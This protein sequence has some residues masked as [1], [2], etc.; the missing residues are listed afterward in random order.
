MRNQR[1]VSTIILSWMISTGLFAQQL[2]NAGFE[3]WSGEKYDNNIQPASWHA[4]NVTQV[5]FKFT[6][7]HQ[8]S[9]HTGNYCMQVGDQEV[10]AMGITETAPGYFSLGNSWCYLPSITKIKEATAGTEGGIAW[11]YRPDSVSVWI[12]RTGNNVRKENFNIVYYAWSGTTKGEKYKGKNGNCSPTSHTDE[13]GD[14]RQAL[15]GNDCGTLQKANQIAEGWWKEMKEYG[16]WTNLRIPIYYINNDVP[17][18]MNLLF[19]AGNYPNFCSVDG[20]YAG[21]KLF[22][23]DVSL[24]Y[25]A[26]IQQI[27]IDDK[28]WKGFDSNS[29]DE[30]TYSLG[31]KATVMPKIECRR[32]VG[33]LTNMR[34][35]TVSFPGRVLQGSECVITP[36]VIDGKPTEIKVTSD[37][38]QSTKIYK[39][40]FVRAPSTNAKLADLLVNGESIENFNPNNISY[41]VALPFGT[42][43]APVVSVVKAED[44]QTVT[45]T[46]S[47]STTG[48][49]TVKVTA[50]DKKTTK[51]Y[52]ISFSV[53][54]LADN[55]LTDITV[56]GNS[57][58]DFDSYRSL[59][60]ISLPLNTTTMPKVVGLSAYPA[61]AQ[62]ITYKA[63]AQIDGGKY[64][65][66]VSV[67][68]NP[69]TR[70]YTLTF[71]LEPS[72]YSL[73]KD[74]SMDGGYITGFDPHNFTYYVD[75][76]LGTNK[77][78]AIHYVKGD[79]YQTV[80]IDDAAGLEGTNRI[81]V[82]A[83]DGSQ[84]TYKLIT[85][86]E[87]S[88]RS[89]LKDIKVG[90]V[91]ISGFDPNKTTYTYDLPIGTS[92][93][94]TIEPVPGDEFEEIQVL[95]N[96]VNGTTRI[97]V[98]AGD[99]NTTIYQITFSVKK[100]SDAT[101]KSITLDGTEI[102]NYN[103]ETLEYTVSL[104]KGTT[105]HPTVGYVPNDAFQ[106]INV[107]DGGLNGDYKITVRPQSGASRE[108]IIHFKV[109][110]SSNVT[111]KDIAIGGTTIEN[112]APET[113]DYTIT[114]APGI[115]TI[116]NNITYVPAEASQKIMT[117]REGMKYVIRVTAESGAR[118]EY[119]INFIVQKSQN[120]F[121]KDILLDG[122]SIPNFDKE[123]FTYASILTGNYSPVITAVP[124]DEGQQV[125]ITAPNAV[126][127]AQI[128]VIPEQGAPNTYTI[129]FTK[130]VSHNVQL[131]DIAVDGTT[132]TGFDPTKV[133]YT[134]T[135]EDNVP[136][137][138]YTP[139]TA[140]QQVDK[141]T[142]KNFVYLYVTDGTEY[143]TY[144]IDLQK[145]L[146]S[147]TSITLYVDGNAYMYDPATTNVI[148][149]A[150]GATDPVIT[151][152]AADY[153][154]VIYAGYKDANTYVLSAVSETGTVQDYTLTIVR[155]KYTDAVLE[156]LTLQGGALATS[157]SLD[158]NTFKHTISDYDEG[159]AL[160]QII[161]K[162]KAGQ[163]VLVNEV[164]QTK[165]Q[166]IVTAEDGTTNTY[167]ITYIPTV[168]DNALL[169]DILIDNVALQGFDPNTHTYT[170]SLP[171]DT[172]V[173]PC[174]HPV[175]QLD[176]QT[177][178]TK[179]G[180]IDAPTV[181]EVT[182][183]DGITKTTYTLNFPV[184]RSNNCDLKSLDIEG[185]SNFTFDKDITDYDIVLDRRAV[186]VPKYYY[187]KT[188]SKQQIRCVS[189]PIGQTSE[190]TVI[191][192]DGTTKTYRL[193]FHVDF[194]TDANEL[195]TLT[196]NGYT[197][198]L[199]T[200]VY[201]YN[202]PLMPYGTK[203]CE[204]AYTKNYDEQTVVVTNGGIYR[205]TKIELK[206]NRPNESNTVYTITP[207][208]DPQ[209]P[210]VAE[211][212]TIGG[213]DLPDFDKNRFTYVYDLKNI[214]TSKT[215]RTYPYDYTDEHADDW[216]WQGTI[217]KD[218]F[219]NT[220][221]IYFH[222]S[223]DKIPNNH[224][225]EW[226]KT[227]K[228]NSDKPKDWNAPG[229]YL[230][231]YPDNIFASIW[232]SD[233]VSKADATTVHLRTKNGASIMGALPAKINLADMQAQFA[234]AGGSYVT[235]SGTKAFHNTPDKAIMKYRY[236]DM[237]GNGAL[238]RFVFQTKNGLITI[239]NLDP[240]ESSNDT[241]HSKDLG[242]AGM[243]VSAYD[244]IIDATGNAKSSGSDGANLYVD[245]VDFVYNNTA[246]DLTVNNTV[247]E[248]TGK[249][250]VATLLSAE[251]DGIPALTFN[252]EVVDQAQKITWKT[253]TKDADNETRTAEIINYGEDGGSQTYTLKVIR[254]LSTVTTLK[255]ITLT[256]G[257]LKEAFSEGRT[258][259]TC[260]IPSTQKQLPDVQFIPT[261]KLETLTT[262]YNAQDST[263]T[264]TVTSEKKTTQTY[265]LKFITDL[266]SDADLQSLTA[267]GVSY[268]P[269]QTDYTVTAETLPDITFSKKLDGQVVEQNEKGVI[270][271]TAEDGTEKTYRVS[272]TAPEDV[273]VAQLN[274]IAFN[275]NDY[276]GGLG[277]GSFDKE[278]IKRINPTFERMDTRDS[279]VYT[280]TPTGL[281]W[282]VVGGTT[283]GGAEKNTY[284]Y[285]YLVE[286]S[287]NTLL[288]DITIDG[289]SV[290][291]FAPQVNDYIV[292]TNKAI[293]VDV[294]KAE[295]VQTVTTTLTGNKYVI[296]VTAE[297]GTTTNTYSVT[298]TPQLSDNAYLAQLCVDGTNILVGTQ[299]DYVQEIP[300]GAAKVVEPQMPSITYVVG[301]IGQ[302]VQVDRG[303]LG[304]PTTLTVTSPDGNNVITYNV[305]ISAEPSHNALLNNIAINGTPVDERFESTRHYYTYIATTPKLNIT[306]SSDDN[307][308][309]VSEQVS[310]DSKG[311][312]VHS[313]IVTAQDGVT[314]NKY[315]VS[316]VRMEV[317]H[318]TMLSNILLDN[319]N[320]TVYVPELNT[321]LHFDANNNLYSVNLQSTITALPDVAALLNEDGQE[322]S[323]ET[324][325]DDVLLHVTAP[326]GT[327]KN[328]YTVSFKR[329]KSNNANLDDIL[330]DGVSIPNF[331]PEQYYYFVDLPIGTTTIPE[332]FAQKHEEPQTVVQTDE[333]NKTVLTVT[334]EDGVTT[335][336]YDILYNFLQSDIDTLQ[337][338]Y[339]DG[340]PVLEHFKGFEFFY[341]ITLPVGTTTIP[342]LSW[343]EGDEWQTV[344]E[345]PL[346]ATTSQL[347]VTSQSGKR[348]IYTVEFE[349]LLSDVDTLAGLYVNGEAVENF[350]S[351]TNEYYITLP[352]D[353]TEVPDLMWLEG[354]EYQTITQT[355]LVDVMMGKS[356]GQKVEL[357]VQAQKGNSRTYTLHFPV[358]LSD[359][360]L[361][362]MIFVSGSPV[363]NYDSETD[364]YTITLPLEAQDVP[365]VTVA[366]KDD[367][368]Q[369]D[370]DI[371]KENWV[372]TIKVVAEDGVS[373]FTYTLTFKRAKS[374]DALLKDLLVG[375]E[376]MPD[377]QSQTYEYTI[378]IP[379]GVT[380]KPTITPVAKSADQTIEV[381]DEENGVSI[382]VTAADGETQMQY[383]VYFNFLKN[384]DAYLL[385]ITL[386]D[387]LLSSFDKDSSEFYVVLPIGSTENDYFTV[388]DFKATPSDPLAQ[389]E[390]VAQDA[391]TIVFEVTAQNGTTRRTYIVHQSIALSSDNTLKMI[392]MDGLEYR[393]FAPKVTFYTYLLQEGQ[394]PPQIEAVPNYPKA[395]VSYKSAIVGD[396]TLI[397]C[398]AEDGSVKKYQILFINSKENDG[399]RPEANDILIKRVPGSYDIQV[400]SIRKGVSMYIFDMNGYM[401][402]HLQ[403]PT[404][405]PNDMVVEYDA[406]GNAILLDVYTADAG[407]TLTLQP[408]KVYFYTFFENERTK[409]KSGKLLVEEK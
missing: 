239:D 332:V 205:P 72:S 408:N 95:T 78:P 61:G 183:A 234:V 285:T 160:P 406:F 271:V 373:N 318:N 199:K 88:S 167:N 375:E 79:E 341:H 163:T 146:H 297:D 195:K 25:S 19:S 265:T 386:N 148:N 280:Q 296:V 225:T 212:I 290:D 203:E 155:A 334:A 229:D 32:G 71:K 114:L 74:L 38:K 28:Q 211:R 54:L 198:A 33:A 127:V 353:A 362:N 308:Q 345:H 175:G 226:T 233:V 36:G 193:Y 235:A 232:A 404:A 409:I 300:V 134:Y 67:P 388:E 293:N 263:Y 365:V 202:T 294:V 316:V 243:N 64:L 186:E 236:P 63:P 269:A 312:E 103:R 9:G 196:V 84:S 272:L 51:T 184:K 249:Q 331:V 122:V 69:A 102:P 16:D 257:R 363:S 142:Q 367:K 277:K 306:Y 77:L 372:V 228:S 391:Q 35:T 136:M 52:T 254:P 313:I 227:K 154:Q 237:K 383:L 150:A 270:K 5:G 4:S 213:V 368:Q 34:G 366:K 144:T 2:P 87:L 222:Y 364:K 181:I 217:K 224:F 44:A 110:V 329:V 46:Q 340:I 389:V 291:G 378:D 27:F 241:E 295:D 152:K 374:T 325:N 82:T 115:S 89:D 275:G 83:A 121:L 278:D 252:G 56:N 106:I 98:K 3:D 45:I 273:T 330:L 260:H 299:T 86:T 162:S 267:T 307:F 118:R 326:D 247:A 143:N 376:S 158:V 126:G 244:V 29:S 302:Q 109:E 57:I 351:H 268:V 23:D 62:T 238:F 107:R 392:Y 266:S 197:I 246:K 344:T 218:G 68:G 131:K 337:N 336:H 76:P 387:T 359:D 215:I 358:K 66:S 361:L 242:T 251:E 50:A 55:T 96:G 322:V 187:T 400:V 248:L 223:D 319:D 201:T 180:K 356:L 111:L 94:P 390:I 189:R 135:Y 93:L 100:A 53:A 305:T 92:Q 276:T 347:Y 379:Y 8:A 354:D 172:K 381:S 10:G 153:T 320:M 370:I 221:T 262:T 385:S 43:A 259:Y 395:Q 39:I 350:E 81:I 58:N 264:V 47:N 116:P 168:S 324:I 137:V 97:T 178:V 214:S 304:Q 1:L 309:T 349:T 26:N 250:F 91:S 176:N 328:T 369:V 403:V 292:P 258:A 282:E 49:A 41:N 398:E 303:G 15:N 393:D 346:S 357:N 22:I 209:N 124:S 405:S 159:A 240:N 169:K 321:G 105:V 256:N 149:V 399:A 40:K 396:T 261:S 401:L 173:V 382:I 151:Y 60:N 298:L 145:Q 220:Y 279:V 17:E 165:Q 327:T 108:Y 286:K 343:F 289:T 342:E 37:D 80:E 188:Q 394:L 191:A 119:A 315:E 65:V 219:E 360:C 284:T 185:V 397:F 13:E 141:F 90:G 12:K 338:I 138:T 101:L 339:Y 128:R 129:T 402:W 314:V 21:N 30:Q 317:S 24:I 161:Y 352:S 20:L 333:N 140:N 99:G 164:S 204:V 73:L 170:V 190:I 104:P 125:I 117:Y 59:Y 380:T 123:L 156:S 120:A 230:T 171:E 255:G 157:K 207:K 310:T 113:T 253:C 208:V 210:A 206:S 274:T 311:R 287:H 216:H 192:E 14:I 384:D 182:A 7:G 355:E 323:I 6:F 283:A 371:D 194:P 245:Y 231:K 177:I 348:N 166:V 301:E 281:S 133:N 48:K 31:E 377:F 288:R 42:T 200:G 18:K 112:F 139:A 179:F 75:L 85:S 407:V 70:T 174:V 130:P 132:I 335:K 11:R 147:S